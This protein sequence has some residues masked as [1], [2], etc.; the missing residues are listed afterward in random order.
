MSGYMSFAGSSSE[1]SRT[2]VL[3][4]LR[5]ISVAT[6]DA[7]RELE[8]QQPTTAVRFNLYVATCPELSPGLCVFRVEDETCD[9][10]GL[11]EL[12]T[13]T[14]TRRGGMADAVRN[15]GLENVRIVL[16]GSYAS[17]DEAVD[18][19]RMAQTRH[20]A[21]RLRQQLPPASN[22]GRR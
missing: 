18:A 16:A 7:I 20:N 10:E 17:R 5:A 2:C 4:A 21:A 22:S 1:Q 8:W 13:S 12:L 9:L 3:T 11:R 15:H 19:G 14:L 6:A